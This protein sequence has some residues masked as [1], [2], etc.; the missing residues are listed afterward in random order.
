MNFL[1]SL[2]QLLRQCKRRVFQRFY[3]AHRA[4][5]WRKLRES[6]EDIHGTGGVFVIP[7][8]P[9]SLTGSRGDE[10]MLIVL[11]R[12]FPQYRYHVVT[13]TPEAAEAARR[14]GWIPVNCWTG[15]WLFESIYNAAKAIRPTFCAVLGADVMDGYY[16][17]RSSIAFFALADIMQRHGIPTSLIGFSF[18]SHPHPRVLKCLRHV[19]ADFIYRLRDPISLQRFEKATGKRALL[20]ADA[21]FLL[22]PDT[23]SEQYE[24]IQEWKRQSGQS[25]LAVNLHPM[26][27]KNAT[28][29]QIAESV[30]ALANVLDDILQKTDWNLLLLPHDDRPQVTDNICLEPLYEKLRRGYANRIHYC[31]QVLDAPCIKGVVSLADALVTSRMHLGI[32]GLS[33]GIPTM[34][35]SYQDKFLGTLGHFGLGSDFIIP[36]PV[37]SNCQQIVGRL[38]WLLEHAAEIRQGLLQKLPSVQELARRNFPPSPCSP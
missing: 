34:G 22:E 26:L 28:A 11:Q 19:N 9:W 36:P 1:H 2:I 17:P 33:Q 30:E 4:V 25:L 6:Q 37:K 5:E 7:C 32:A 23:H 24:L 3:F 12:H 31:A 14:H 35:F 27:F 21:A 13:S 16:S 10:A 29:T 20:T 8:D 15:R 18:N 38:R